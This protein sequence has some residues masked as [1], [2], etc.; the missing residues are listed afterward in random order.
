MTGIERISRQL[1]H[2]SVDRIAVSEEFWTWTASKWIA[3]GKMKEG[4]TPVNHFNLDLD[5]LWTFKYALHPEFE[6][7]ILEEDEDTKLIKDGNNALLRV[8]KKHAST[9]EHI[10]YAVANREDW[11]KLA[12]PFLKPDRNRIKWDEY[13]KRKAAAAENNRF[14]CWSGIPIF[15]C[16]HPICGHENLLMG[17]ALDPDWIV[18]MADAYTQLNIDLME[19]LFAEA[20]QPDGI[21]FY[22]DMGFRGR[23]FMSPEMYRELIMPGHKRLN[24]YV[25]SRGMKVIMHSCGFVEP[26]L[27][28]MIAS[29]IDCLEAIEVKAGMDLLRI[30]KNFGDKIALMGGLDV[31]PIAGN[32]LEGI[33]RELESKIPFV[34]QNYGFILHSDHSIPESTEYDSYRYFL[35]LGLK[36]GTY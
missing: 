22:E 8:H 36:L 23:P 13:R 24:D 17:M 28:D 15:E 12:K 32:D 33:R 4:E 1:N 18:E 26:L 21:W 29:G 20:G 14:F 34:K 31:R 11:E 25:H 7:E 5:K 9:P 2:Q 30:Y 3:D 19:I 10:G 35:E 16:I 27:P 6:P